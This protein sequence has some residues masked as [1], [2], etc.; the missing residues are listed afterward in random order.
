VH[1]PGAIARHE[2]PFYL[3]RTK[4]ALVTFPDPETGVAKA[5]FTRRQVMTA[6]FQIGETELDLYDQLT[7]YV[8]QQSV[9]ASQDD[10]ARGR[11]VGFTMAMLQR[12]FSSSV[13]AVRRTLE[14][15]RDK[16]EKILEDPGKYR[17]EQITRRLPEDFDDLPEEEQLEI[18]AELEDAVASYDPND[19]RNEIADLGG[20]IRNARALETQESE[21]KVRRLK[22]LLTERGIFSDPT[23][24]IAR[25]HGA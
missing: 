1:N 20:L 23:M 13:Y 7:Q 15:M 12:R 24:K 22:D 9:K 19:L 18:M 5:L 6:P 17:Y 3:R 21:V 8:E 16:R 2:A 14:R 10:S 4:E 25:V 11:A